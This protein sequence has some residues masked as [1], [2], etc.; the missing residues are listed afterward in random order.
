MV[1]HGLASMHEVLPAGGRR[2]NRLAEA[3]WPYRE[4]AAWKAAEEMSMS[5]DTTVGAPDVLDETF[6]APAEVVAAFATLGAWLPTV[7][8]YSMTW[9]LRSAHHGETWGCMTSRTVRGEAYYQTILGHA[10]VRPC[11]GVILHGPTAPEDVAAQKKAALMGDAMAAL[12]PGELRSLADAL[13]ASGVS[14]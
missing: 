2:T 5:N 4:R 6:T 10:L 14:A 12:S 13:E 1:R 9:G 7:G 3:G 8:A 11:D